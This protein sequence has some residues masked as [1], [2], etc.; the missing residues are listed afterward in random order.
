MNPLAHMLAGALIGQVSSSAPWAVAGGI[1][2]HALLDAT[3]HAEGETFGMQSQSLLRPDI[4]EAGIEAMVGIVVLWR[5]TISCPAARAD[6]VT[7]G[8]LGGLL[9]DLVDIPLKATIGRTILHVRSLHGTV[10]RKHA[11]WGILA[12]VVT[13]GSAAILLWFSSCR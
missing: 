1:A 4:V 6:L 11:A 10:R 3:P 8:A 2:S 13:A 9:P 7:F 5:L 12:Q